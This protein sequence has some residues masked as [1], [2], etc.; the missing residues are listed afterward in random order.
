VSPLPA[1]PS[2]DLLLVNLDLT[3]PT[4]GPEPGDEPPGKMP[5]AIDRTS[6]ISGPTRP[7][8]VAAGR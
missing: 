7:T 1:W 5:L 8:R 3:L 4:R 6:R 2:A